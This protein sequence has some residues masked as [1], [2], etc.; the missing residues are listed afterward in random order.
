[1]TTTN[2]IAAKIAEEQGLSRAQAKTVV[3]AVFAAVTTAAVSDAETS[4]PGFGKFK[5]KNTPE[6]DARNP[7]TGATIKVAA[8]KKLVFT[9]AKALKDALNCVSAS[10]FGSDSLLMNSWRRLA[11]VLQKESAPWFIR[12]APPHSCLE[13]LSSMR[14]LLLATRSYSLSD[15]RIYPAVVQ[16]A[17]QDQ[18]GYTVVIIDA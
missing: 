16:A 10:N 3:E 12:F 8:A 13:A 7:A 11:L 9:P 5:V 17:E 4:I 15:R 18:S 2:E 14:Q 6:R 1:M